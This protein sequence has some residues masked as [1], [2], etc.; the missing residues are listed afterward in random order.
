MEK[1]TLITYEMLYDLLRLEKSH[2]EPQKLDPTF[3]QQVLKY[4]QEKQ[5]ILESQEGKDSVFTSQNVVKTRKQVE[6]I[7]KIL[8]ELY[9]KRESKILQSSLL[10]ARTV[11]KPQEMEG[12]LAEEH[13]LYEQLVILLSQFREGV[14]YKLLEG[15]QPKVELG[16]KTLK[17]QEKNPD[18]KL[19]RFLHP[20]PQFVGEDLYVYGPFDLDDVASLPLKVSEVLL[21]NKRVEEL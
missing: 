11:G 5:K 4:L 6:N 18:Q 1:D 8:R 20:V 19:V 13:L 10:I 12:F 17:S 21:K 9:E 14:L 2:T 15:K 7:Q 3:Y 16:P